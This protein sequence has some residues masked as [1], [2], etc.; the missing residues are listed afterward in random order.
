MKKKIILCLLI[1]LCLC[2]I[3]GCGSKSKKKKELTEEERKE[4]LIKDLDAKCEK[5]AQTSYNLYKQ[6]HTNKITNGVCAKESPGEYTVYFSAGEEL[7]YKY[8]YIVSDDN[9]KTPDNDNYNTEKLD[10]YAEKCEDYFVDGSIAAT[11]TNH[12]F[13]LNE[14]Q[15]FVNGI[16]D[17]PTVYKALDISK[18]K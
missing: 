13:M 15:K 2:T 14:Y 11:C 17:R 9:I 12:K 7:V 6:N 1:L 5:A 8:T 18:L 4:E 10:E 16:K 3:S